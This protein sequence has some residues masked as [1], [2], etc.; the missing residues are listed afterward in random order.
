MDYTVDRG[1]KV[2]SGSLNLTTFLT[3]G[4]NL[5]SPKTQGRKLSVE[6]FMR[7][8]DML[9]WPGVIGL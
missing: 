6:C 4:N 3:V 9:H 5:T 2:E 7:V 1:Q 8:R